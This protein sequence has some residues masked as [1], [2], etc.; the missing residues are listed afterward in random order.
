MRIGWKLLLVL[1]TVTGIGAWLMVD[2]RSLGRVAD[3]W[4]TLSTSASHASQSPSSKDWISKQSEAGN[5]TPDRMVT[6]TPDQIKGIGLKT[7]GVKAQSE[8]IILRLQGMTDYD[9]HTLTIVRPQFDNSRVEKVLVDLGSVVKVGDPLLEIF[10][11]DLADAKSAYETAVSQHSR[12]ERMLEARAPLAA[13][14][15]IP[16][17]ELIEMKNDEAKS[18]LQMKLAKDK[19]LVYG[20][21]EKEILDV[22]SEDGVQKARMILRSRAAGIVIK[23]VAVQGNYYDSKDDLMEIAPLEHLKVWVTV[24]ELDADKVELDQ[25]IRVIFPFSDQEIEAKVEY[26][27][28]AIDPETRAARFRGTVPNP[29]KRFKARMFVRVLLEIPPKEGHT[30]IPR[31]AMVSVDRLDFVYVKRT[32]VPWG[33]ERRQIMV[34]KE[35]SDWVVVEE[36]TKD[37]LGLKPSEEIVTN[38]SLILEQ[39]YEDRLTLQGQVPSERPRDDEVFGTVGKPAYITRD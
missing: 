35:T 30:I 24:S 11:T 9:Q 27:D 26:I 32:D 19:L 31:G 34:N 5:G 20:L 16:G 15:A 12:D 37:H 33:F 3:V 13:S 23:R 7:V 36:P 28:K 38:G 14:T 21:T 17:K 39:M 1:T 18:R 6:L 8:P 4:R 2:N 29:G 22:A 25:K 10:S